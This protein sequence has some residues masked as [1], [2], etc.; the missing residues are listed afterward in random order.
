MPRLTNSDFHTHRQFLIQEWEERD[1]AAF[2]DLPMQYQRD[3][4]DYYAPT[5]SFT[6]KES[7]AHRAAMT[8]AFPPLPQKAGRAYQAIQ[9]AVDGVPNPIVDSHREATT[10]I[11]MIGGKRRTLRVTGVARPT[12]DHYRLARALVGLAKDPVSSA[13]LDKLVGKKRRRQSGL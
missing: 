10:S 5:V 9:A 7:L 11:E 6:A 12:V 2:A 13:R 8:S 3:L 1:G 4:H